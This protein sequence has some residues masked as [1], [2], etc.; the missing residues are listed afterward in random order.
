MCLCILYNT[1]S[2]GRAS[3]P[4]DVDAPSYRARLPDPVARRV[5]QIP[6]A[7]GSVIRMTVPLGSFSSTSNAPP[8]VS[9]V[10]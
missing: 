3:L 1:V 2:A 5:G 8:D 6:S 10:Q 9:T 7:V 4:R